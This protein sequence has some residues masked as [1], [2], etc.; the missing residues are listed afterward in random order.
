V[1]FEGASRW[2]CHRLPYR[3]GVSVYSDKYGPYTK[4]VFAGDGLNGGGENNDETHAGPDSASLSTDRRDPV[5]PQR[6]GSRSTFGT[7]P[8]NVVSSINVC[9]HRVR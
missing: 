9:T 2:T 3:R 4:N 6:F 5:G 7:S 8:Y 1:K